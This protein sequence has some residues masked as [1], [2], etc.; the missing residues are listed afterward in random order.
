[1]Q[2]FAS[3]K[4]TV[5]NFYKSRITAVESREFSAPESYLTVSITTKPLISLPPLK[6]CW[7]ISRVK[8][9]RGLT[10]GRRLAAD[11]WLTA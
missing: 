8:K 2:I 11:S 10:E 5:G 6:T 3:L 7:S 9:G 1:M 4:L